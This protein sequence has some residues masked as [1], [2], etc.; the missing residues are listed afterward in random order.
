M[1]GKS[2]KPR[3]SGRKAPPGRPALLP[4]AQHT[5]ENIPNSLSAEIPQVPL[6]LDNASRSSLWKSEEIVVGGSRQEG[7]VTE[8]AV[9]DSGTV[10]ELLE[11]ISAL[12]AHQKE[13]EASVDEAAVVMGELERQKR[14][15]LRGIEKVRRQ[16]K[17]RYE[18]EMK[19]RD[20][21]LL[22]L[23]EELK[24]ERCLREIAEGGVKRAEEGAKAG[25]LVWTLAAVGRHLTG[26]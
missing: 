12:C 21:E 25:T 14:M 26:T 8:Q 4:D 23:R 10:E 15:E 22:K 5:K 11:I 6:D 9:T 1:D 19:R 20:V 2:I 17:R 16:D 7:S 18:K 24:R 13:I 3:G